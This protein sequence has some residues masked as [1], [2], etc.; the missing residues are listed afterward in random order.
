MRPK[1]YFFSFLFF[2]HF[3]ICGGLLRYCKTLKGKYLI[4]YCSKPVGFAEIFGWCRT[5][6]WL[7][8]TLFLYVVAISKQGG[9]FLNIGSSWICKPF[10]PISV[11][12]LH[13]CKPL[14]HSSF[15]IL[16]KQRIPLLRKSHQTKSSSSSLLPIF[17]FL[18]LFLL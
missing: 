12:S 16:Y 15:P 5:W 17:S 13:S 9:I 18:S 10:P 1:I 4:T 7:L 2:K 11:L 6:T 14:S 8:G 3:A